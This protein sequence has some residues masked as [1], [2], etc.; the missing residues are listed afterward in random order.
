M[1]FLQDSVMVACVTNRFPGVS[2]S[3]ARALFLVDRSKLGAS[4]LQPRLGHRCS[5]AG[6]CPL[7]E[8]SS[9]LSVTMGSSADGVH[10]TRTPPY[11]YLRS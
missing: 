6:Y 10:R 8:G 5:F 4:L 3:G 7:Y 2:G 11:I 1:D 9:I